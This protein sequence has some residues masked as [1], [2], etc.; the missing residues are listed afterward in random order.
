MLPTD[1]W[2]LV[3]GL[4]TQLH[5]IH[6]LGVVRT[7]N[8]VD[9]GHIETSRGVAAQTATALRALGYALRPAVDPRDN[10]AHRFY[11]GAT[12]TDLVTARPDAQTEE[13][14]DVLVPTTTLRKSP[15]GSLVATWSASRAAHKRCDAPATRVWR[16]CPE[17]SPRSRCPAP[18]VRSS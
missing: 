18:S 6:G 12:K 15:N 2:T 14:V 1:K 13:V 5:S 3:G 7:T 17:P 16:S 4:M 8:D 9:I 10:T 11:R